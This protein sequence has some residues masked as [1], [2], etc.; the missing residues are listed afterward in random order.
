[1]LVS[2]ERDRRFYLAFPG[3]IALED[4]DEGVYPWHGI[5]PGGCGNAPDAGDEKRQS[6]GNGSSNRSEFIDEYGTHHQIEKAA[7]EIGAPC[8][9]R[10][11]L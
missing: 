7:E 5:S 10:I 3:C 6:C 4:G 8:E 11:F 9:K 2:N 1:M